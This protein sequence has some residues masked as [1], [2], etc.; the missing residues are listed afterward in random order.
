MA[1]SQRTAQVLKES[2]DEIRRLRQQVKNL[3]E[4]E[5]Q[6]V[7]EIAQLKETR[8]KPNEVEAASANS[9][10]RDAAPTAAETAP[11][12]EPHQVESAQERAES[13]DPGSAAEE[14]TEDL[15]PPSGP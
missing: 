11:P 1:Q 6:L 8:E 7:T 5:A 3:K 15:M 12:E 9:G 4:T 10:S 13:S 2:E 14:E